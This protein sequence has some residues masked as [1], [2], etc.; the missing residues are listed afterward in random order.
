MLLCDEVS[1]A[2][3]TLS[4]HRDLSLNLCAERE[5]KEGETKTRE[6][7]LTAVLQDKDGKGFNCSGGN[8]AEKRKWRGDQFW[9]EN[10]GCRGIRD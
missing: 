9:T 2:L 7:H 6:T 8:G 4:Q 3:Y 1:C 10:T 5:L